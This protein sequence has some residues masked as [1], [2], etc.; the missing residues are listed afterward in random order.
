MLDQQTLR[1]RILEIANV[2]VAVEGGSMKISDVRI[3]DA[4]TF[5]DSTHGTAILQDDGSVVLRIS[6]KRPVDQVADTILHEC[7]HVILGPE[8]IDQPDHGKAFQDAYQKVRE[9]YMGVVTGTLEVP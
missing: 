7:A 8:H 5:F 2:I 6:T 9:K 1:A 4:P 3:V